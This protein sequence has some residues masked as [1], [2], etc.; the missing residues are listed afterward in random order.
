M[1]RKNIGQ[2]SLRVYVVHFG[3]DDEAI[4]SAITE[5]FFLHWIVRLHSRG[6]RSGA[7]A[8][9]RSEHAAARRVYRPAM[10][11]HVAQPNCATVLGK[12][13]Y[14]VTYENIVGRDD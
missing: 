3:R 13:I 11:D 9:Q 12:A 6:A 4:C 1:P 10:E 5:R 7:M 2:P 8:G 14:V